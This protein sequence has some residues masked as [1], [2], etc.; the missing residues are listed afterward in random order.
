MWHFTGMVLLSR[1]IQVGKG[2]NKVIIGLAIMHRMRVLLTTIAK[3]ILTAPAG[4]KAGA[5]NVPGTPNTKSRPPE[6]MIKMIKGMIHPG[7]SINKVDIMRM[8]GA[9]IP[10][11]N[12]H[13]N[14]NPEVEVPAT[15]TPHVI[16]SVLRTIIQI[17]GGT[18]KTIGI[19]SSGLPM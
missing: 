13:H 10:P 11:M 2:R 4:L 15:T 8:T 19:P 12:C 5:V 17:G 14:S 16:L 1:V 18:T 7:T 3:M 9:T 6:K